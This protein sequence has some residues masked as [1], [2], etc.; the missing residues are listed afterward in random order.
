MWKR[1]SLQARLLIV[2][3]A[4]ILTALAGG[5]VT[6][7]YSEAIDSLLTDLIDKNVASFQAAAELESAL[8]RQKG[9]V[10][11]YFLDR[12]PSWLS[13]LAEQQR[14]F[15]EWLAK[16]KK[17]AHTADMEK[18]L[19][20]I[21]RS[22]ENYVADRRQVIDL[23]KYN[24]QEEGKRLHWETRQQFYRLYSLCDRYK[25]IH[26]QRIAEA[27]LE[28][29]FKAKLITNTALVIIP[30]V[31]IL[32]L[33]L[34]YILVKQILAPIRQLLQEPDSTAPANEAINEVQALSRKVSHLQEDVDQAQTQLKQSQV[35]L[36]QS[37]KLAM[38]G[39]LAAGV[40]HSIRNPLTSVK[41]RLYSMRRHLN[42]PVGQLEDLDVISQE[43]GHI[44]TIVRNFLEYARPPKLTIQQCSPSAVIDM[45]L[46]LLRPRLESFKVLVHLNRQQ[47]LPE[48]WA[49]PDQ[50]KEVFV[51]LIV[52]ACEAMEKGGLITITETEDFIA[53]IGRVVQIVIQD[54]GPGI[55]EG[56]QENIFQP[57]FTSREEGTGLGL[58][59]AL[60]IIQ[61]HGG[62]IEVK[63]PP[64]QGA[65]FSLTLPLRRIR[66]GN[67]THS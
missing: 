63:S 28:S 15:E 30:G 27:K 42:L 23:Y 12:N 59:I 53:G 24:R 7:W 32:G 50:L 49:D 31:G 64:G 13:E 46:T 61:E 45:A 5:L 55:P 51:N 38:V 67:Y 54:T 20:Q 39:K 56:M 37:E 41:M 57:F 19:Q 22:Y 17:S 43:I 6:V 14:N 65:I 36:V 60:R 52:N 66:H 26:E 2:L 1:L 47:P 18:L 58:S 35:H 9:S 3:A 11:Y 44:D 16:A 25:F 21:A 40:A 4:L 29:G 10:T 48:I 62:W 34:A 33:L 8:L